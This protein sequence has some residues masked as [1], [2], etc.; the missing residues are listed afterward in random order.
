MSGVE[1]PGTK[2]VDLTGSITTAGEQSFTPATTTTLSASTRYFVVLSTSIGSVDI[3][4][5]KSDDEDSGGSTGW[6]IAD[7]YVLS[8]DSGITW[9]SFDVSLVIAVKGTAVATVTDTTAPA[10]ESAAANGTSLVITFDEDL[11]AAA[12]LANSAFT[13]KKTPSGGTEATV[14]LS[15]TSAPVISGRTVTLTLA[16]ALVSTDTAVKVTYTA[17]TTGSNNKLVDAASNATVTFTDQTVTNNTPATDTT[18]VITIAAGTSSVTKGTAAAFTLTRTGS[19]TAE[20][21]VNVTVSESGDMVASANEGAKTATFT[22]NSA[23][24]TLSVATVGDSVDEANSVVTA[25]VTVDTATPATYTVGTPASATVTVTDNDRTP[26]SI[27]G[28][29]GGGFGP[30]LVALKFVDGFRTSRT[31][32]LTARVGDAVGDPVA[33]THPR[34]S[35]ITYSL[36]GTDAARFTVDEETGQIRLGQAITLAL[37][38][39]YTVNLTATDTSGTGAIII[40]AIEVGEAPYHRYDLN[41]NGSIEKNEALAAVGDYFGGVIEKPLVLEV[42]SLYFAA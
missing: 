17:P 9:L 29:G 42:V 5:T 33:A 41:R 28:G 2:V 7:N 30:A 36:S 13:V 22:A 12:S 34:N 11:A 19:A 27:T 39:T 31:L 18:P 40:V 4:I 26:P 1:V 8:T 10:F 32:T 38:Q 20:L 15:T 3:R 23:T 35:E 21:S 14:T 37:G 16:T 6:E 25:T 24:A